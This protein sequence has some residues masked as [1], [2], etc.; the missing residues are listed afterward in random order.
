MYG[1]GRDHWFVHHMPCLSL[2]GYSVRNTVDLDIGGLGNIL[3]FKI[4]HG[5]DWHEEQ[6]QQQKAC[7][8]DGPGKSLAVSKTGRA[9]MAEDSQPRPSHQQATSENFPEE[10]SL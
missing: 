5:E 10:D 8:P 4:S 2:W 9:L 3:H 7:V 1:S 6:Q